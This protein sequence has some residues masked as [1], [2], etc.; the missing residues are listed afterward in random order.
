MNFKEK[1]YTTQQMLESKAYQMRVD[2]LRMTT[3][4]GSGH[5]TSA[6]SAADVVAALFFYRMNY[7]FANPS[8]E[9]NDRFILS[10]GH[11]SPILYAAFKQ[12]GVLTDQDI[13]GYRD[14]DS[15]LEGHPTMRFTY[16][17]AATGSLGIGLSIGVGMA[18]YAKMFAKKFCTFVLLG[19]SE[20]AEG[21]VWEAAEIAAYYAL[22]NI[23]AF[24]DC[25]RLGQSCQTIHGY[26]L[27]RYAAKFKAFG[28]HVIM[29]DG[30]DM[31]Q[32]MAAL[33]AA[34]QVDNQPVVI[35]A[36]TIKGYGI[37]NAE[38][39]Q[40]FHGKVFNAQELPAILD[41]LK[42]RFAVA[43]QL[44]A[45]P[46]MHV[47][48]VK[49]K[50]NQKSMLHED[51][52]VF[53]DLPAPGYS[54]NSKIATRKAFGQVLEALGAACEKMVV[55]DAEVKNSTYTEF[56]EHTFSDR[57]VQCFI[58]EQNMISMAV[59]FE[60]RGALPFVATF[61]AFF[62]R[63]YDQIRMAAIGQSALRL[64]GSHA[65]ISIGQDGPSQMAL[66]DIALMRALPQSIVL[67]PC[68]GIS[69]YYLT[70]LMAQ[71]TDGISYLRTTRMETPVLY[72]ASEK[73]VIGGC[74]V[75]KK[76][77][78]DSVC[79][80]AAGITVFQALQAYEML[81]E[82]GITISV[83]DL[84]SIKPLDAVTL[85]EIVRASGGKVITVEDH[86][87]QGGLGQAV[88]YELR[89][90]NFSVTCLAVTQLPRSG[91]PEQLLA[92]AGIDAAAIVRTILECT[93]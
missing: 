51:K 54:L 53:L 38:D 5:P 83:I 35:L 90:H 17:E 13:L 12:A 15:V 68:D 45:D 72:D 56:F 81:R 70:Q 34:Q 87:L 7:D 46:C 28:W 63:A 21:S 25:N 74:K 59:G 93:T 6:L 75:L 78:Q 1:N 9:N 80:V 42:Q 39:K 20:I 22:N 58:A 92:W 55:F 91:T 18:L 14:F 29:V 2:A 30:H 40:G 62:S 27:E 11:A 10:K 64:V 84:Y 33:D 60:R 65:G 61:G 32:I 66:E 73:F 69:T 43:A 79:V 37:E 82:Q 41:Q 77:A 71:Y 67:Y 88:V 85:V 23:V 24:V 3:Q 36:K 26:H 86:Y 49:N 89:N 48:L 76:S 57:F 4:A 16:T 19:D 8:Y 50:D 52:N 31:V 44:S 47:E